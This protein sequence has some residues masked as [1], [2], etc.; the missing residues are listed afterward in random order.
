MGKKCRPHDPS[1]MAREALDALREREES[2]ETNQ[3]TPPDN[4]SRD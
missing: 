1:F 4:R 3:T 2:F